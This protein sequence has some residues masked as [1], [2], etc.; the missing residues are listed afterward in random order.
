MALMRNVIKATLFALVIAL[1]TPVAAPDFEAGD[2]AYNRGDYAAALRE[3]R[4]L[5]EQGDALAQAS[6]GVMYRLGWGVP[7]D[8]VQAHL[9]WS[10]A[11]SQGNKNAASNRD[12]V[13]GMMTPEQIAEAE[14]LAREWKPK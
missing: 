3:W 2:K 11:A 12:K 1:A 7:L 6:L 8:Y 13:A 10:L 4:P 14:K 9:W 5:A